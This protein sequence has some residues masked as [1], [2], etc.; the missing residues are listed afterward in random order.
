MALQTPCDFAKA[1]YLDIKR[2][3]NVWGYIWIGLGITVAVFLCLAIVLFLRSN[4][5]PGALSTLGTIV[6]GA[7]MAWITTQRQTAANEEQQAFNEL[8][9]QCGPPAKA[10]LQGPPQDPAEAVRNAPWFR[11]LESA[12]ESGKAA[13]AFLANLRHQ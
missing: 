7:V 12:A 2:V 3:R 13:K 1:R 6:N 9:Q 11:E 8:V 10:L 5:L 4:W